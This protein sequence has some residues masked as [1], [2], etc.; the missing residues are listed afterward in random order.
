MLKEIGIVLIITVMVY[1]VVTGIAYIYCISNKCE[2]SSRSSKICS[3][4]CRFFK[5]SDWR[6]ESGQK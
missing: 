3:T 6:N 4:K 2:L 5:T 1:F